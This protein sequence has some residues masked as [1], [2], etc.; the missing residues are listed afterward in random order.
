MDLITGKTLK[1]NNWPDGKI[2]GIA[3]EIGNKLIDQGM[4]RESA[5]IKLEA[6]RGDPVKFLT[7]ASLAD[8]ARECIRITQKG[9]I[10]KSGLRETP[11]IYPIWGAD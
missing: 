5:L 8:L 7:D 1:L 3:R 9:S 4:D 11:L 6:V 10:Q 2:I